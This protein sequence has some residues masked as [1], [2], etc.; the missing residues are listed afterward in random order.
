MTWNLRL[1]K[2]TDRRTQRVWY[3]IHEVFYN[4]S[5]KAWGMT[6]DPIQLDGESAEDV[7]KY[8]AMIR[9]D[10]KHT[11]VLDARKI[12]WAKPP[13]SGRAKGFLTLRGL[14]SD[15]RSKTE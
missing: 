2:H 9:H 4:D 12:R 10:L 3:G 7:L 13:R 14:M 11:R 8:L 1:V 5:G 6:K 15:L